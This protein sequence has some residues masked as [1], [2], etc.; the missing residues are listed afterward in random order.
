MAEN[1][2]GQAKMASITVMAG[3]VSVVE[4]SMATAINISG[5]Q[6]KAKRKW[7]SACDVIE[8][9]MAAA[10]EGEESVKYQR[11]RNIEHRISVGA[12]TWRRKK[13]A[14]A[15]ERKYLAGEMWR[16]SIKRRKGSSKIAV[17]LISISIK[18]IATLNISSA[19]AL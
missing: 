6:I 13:S 11:H 16:K 5:D 4:K 18:Y 19:P 2:V 8:A 12:E 3:S 14:L 7:L 10:G 15:N 17:T 9:G 1:N